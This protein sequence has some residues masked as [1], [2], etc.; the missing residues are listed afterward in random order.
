MLQAL[1]D[2]RRRRCGSTENIGTDV[3]LELS[4]VRVFADSPP[5]DLQLRRGEVTVLL[6]LLGSGKS[7]LLESVFGARPTR[8][9]LDAA[10]GSPFAPRHPAEAIDARRLPGARSPARAGD[11]P[12]MVHRAPAL[13]AVHPHCSP[14]RR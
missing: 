9:R 8:R 5:L 10:D 2:R 12:G 11:H 3:V 6:G 1:F 4:D 7:E 14:G 13:V